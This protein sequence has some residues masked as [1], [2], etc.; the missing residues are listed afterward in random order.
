MDERIKKI[1]EKVMG[2]HLS[3][4]DEGYYWYDS[5][6][7]PVIKAT[8]D[9]GLDPWL[10]HWNPLENIADAWQVEDDMAKLHRKAEYIMHLTRILD[11][12]PLANTNEHGIFALI[13]ATP[14]QRCL[15]ALRATGVN[16]EEI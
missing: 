16:T 14:E 3:D 8:D 13:H 5:N 2:W 11:L 12:P 10:E 6:N 7:T 15:A 1:A 9:D 4:D